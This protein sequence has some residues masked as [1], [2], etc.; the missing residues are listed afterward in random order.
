MQ[1]TANPEYDAREA[2]LP[3]LEKVVVCHPMQDD[4]HDDHNVPTS[5]QPSPLRHDD[6]LTFA[7]LPPNTERPR[8]E[9]T[10]SQR[11][12]H[13][14]TCTEEIPGNTR[15]RKLPEGVEE[16]DRELQKRKRLLIKRRI[17][18]S[19]SQSRENIPLFYLYGDLLLIPKFMWVS[20][21]LFAYFANYL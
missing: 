8:T 3:P 5:P 13:I 7:I 21:F 15:K 18:N 20:R 9:K 19:I 4:E 1:L 11:E 2:V 14:C 17:L 16:D 12:A 6:H 10:P